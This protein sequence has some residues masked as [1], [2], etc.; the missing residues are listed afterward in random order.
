M[1]RITL[2]IERATSA[3]AKKGLSPEKT[4]E[5]SQKM[6]MELG[7]YCRFQTLK[8][9]ASQDGRLTFDEAMTIYGLLGNTL[10]HFN[11]QPLPVKWVLTDV[12]ASLLKR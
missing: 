12:F 6:N 5:V 3:I 11:G 8:S 7:E 4:A 2:G 10:E 1:N 9:I